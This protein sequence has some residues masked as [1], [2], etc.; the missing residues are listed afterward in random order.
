MEALRQGN[1]QIVEFAYQKTKNFE[2]LSFLYLITGNQEKLAKML[3]IS[4]MRSDV[5]GQ[6]HNALYL[7][8]IPERVK[9]L[10]SSGHYP[11]A[12]L[13][14]KTHGLVEDADRI[15]AMLKESGVAVPSVDGT[16]ELLTPPAP[17]LREDNWPLLTV[18]KG[19]FEGVLAGD[20]AA[21]DYAAY[22]DED[23]GAG[24]GWGD[25]LDLD[26]GGEDKDQAE[27]DPLAAAGWRPKR[28]APTEKTTGPTPVGTWRI[29]SSPRTWA[30]RRTTWT[31]PCPRFSWRPRRA[32]PPRVA[33]RK[34]RRCPASTPP[35]ATT[36]R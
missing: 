24:A 30:A 10:E 21:N 17:I 33:G 15:E 18:T 25:D 9:I 6:F 28:R 20:V 19:F 1:H 29:S 2:R 34:N 3:K 8:D 11:L 27:I 32:S 13:T 35:P 23:D 31:T 22:A 14:A 7:G 26:L 16:G 4:E 12:Y 5:M 36:R